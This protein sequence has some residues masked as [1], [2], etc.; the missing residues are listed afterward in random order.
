MFFEDLDMW[1]YPGVLK[2]SYYTYFIPRTQSGTL[3]FCHFDGYP[4]GKKRYR[5]WRKSGSPAFSPIYHFQIRGD[6]AV[7]FS[8][9]PPLES[10]TMPFILSC[11]GQIFRRVPPGIYWDTFR[12]YRDDKEENDKT[13][14]IYHQDYTMKYE[15][16]GQRDWYESDDSLL[17][18]IPMSHYHVD[19]VSILEGTLSKRRLGVVELFSKQDFIMLDTI[20]DKLY[21][22]PELDTAILSLPGKVFREEYLKG[23]INPD[24]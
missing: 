12:M 6:T 19:T 1:R 15:E 14:R 16:D 21:K 20:F 9:I 23:R 5:Q 11:D 3:G 7:V 13:Q 4:G 22:Y 8:E 10:D 2:R 17:L 24:R 18:H